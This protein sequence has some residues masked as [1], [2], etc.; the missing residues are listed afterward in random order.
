VVIGG[1]QFDTEDEKGTEPAFLRKKL[2]E[3]GRSDKTYGSRSNNISRNALFIILRPTLT[4][5]EAER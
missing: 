5:Y 4:V 3:T 1:L 2:Q